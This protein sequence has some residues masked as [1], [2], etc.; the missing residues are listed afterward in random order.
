MQHV[1]STRSS[2]F[3]CILLCSPGTHYCPDPAPLQDLRTPLHTIPWTIVPQIYTLWYIYVLFPIYCHVT[4]M[5]GCTP[6]AFLLFALDTACTIHQ[7]WPAC[8]VQGPDDP[9]ASTMHLVGLAPKNKLVLFVL[10][11]TI[12]A[13]AEQMLQSC[14]AWLIVV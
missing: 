4:T 11:K 14:T 7:P 9:F 1:I 5:H 2:P 10:D 13:K 6:V 3:V 12:K 8:C